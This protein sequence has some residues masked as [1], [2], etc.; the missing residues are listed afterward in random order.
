MLSELAGQQQTDGGLDLAARDRR[1][2]VVVSETGGLGGDTL[3]DVVHERIHDAHRLAR[4]TGIG[5]HLLQN[6]VDVDSVALPPSS[7]VLLVTATWRLHLADGLLGALRCCFGRHVYNLSYEYRELTDADQSRAFYSERQL[8]RGRYSHVAV[9]SG[10]WLARG[11]TQ[12]G[13]PLQYK[14]TTRSRRRHYLF[15][16]NGILRS[17]LDEVKEE[18]RRE[19]ARL[20]RRVP[21]FS[22]P[23][24]VFTVICARATTPSASEQ[25]R[26]STWRPSWSIWLL[27]FSSLQETPPATTRSR[28]SSPVTCSSPSAMTRS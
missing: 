20:A 1:A 16:I 21:D 8:R 23:S 9:A 26:P 11:A 13:T 14:R 15:I 6:L 5:V 27:K 4:D 22:S 12:F 24:A 18:R 17:C 7:T 19:R 25:E 10:D 3:E 28:G 2:L